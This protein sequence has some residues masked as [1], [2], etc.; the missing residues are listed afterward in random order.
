MKRVPVI[1]PAVVLITFLTIVALSQDPG[2]PPRVWDDDLKRWLDPPRNWNLPAAYM[3]D[4]DT[5]SGM[6]ITHFAAPDLDTVKRN[7]RSLIAIHGVDGSR[8]LRCRI[9][10][11]ENTKWISLSGARLD[12][13]GGWIPCEMAVNV[14]SYRI[15]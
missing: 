11:R 9:W 12:Q 15:E 6:R 10:D 14:G 13:V 5:E 3:V 8:K 4:L 1:G 7:L 2:P